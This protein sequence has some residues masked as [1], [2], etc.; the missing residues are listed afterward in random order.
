M[1]STMR[2][3][4]QAQ[5]QIQEDQMPTRSTWPPP[6]PLQQEHAPKFTG[7]LFGRT[8][9]LLYTRTRKRQ[10][11]LPWVQAAIH[12]MMNKWILLHWQCVLLMV[13]SHPLIPPPCSSF[14]FLIEW[15]LLHC[16]CVLRM[17][18]S[19]PVL[20]TGVTFHPVHLIHP[21]GCLRRGNRH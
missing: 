1:Q 4:L 19:H 3:L 7:A 6:L 2:R 11:R 13:L 9:D 8:A 5:P 17:V 21:T 14:K 20:P 18:L 15:F 16:Q 12:S 10:L